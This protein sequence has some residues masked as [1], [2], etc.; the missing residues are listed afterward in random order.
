MSTNIKEVIL[1]DADTLEYTGKILVEGGNWQFSEVSND[2]LLKFTKG[3]PLK[4]VLQCLIS[5]NI[6]Y[7]IIEM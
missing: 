3:M 7:D 1:Y 5:F 6:V 2:F 4:A